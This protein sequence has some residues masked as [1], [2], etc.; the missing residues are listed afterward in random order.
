MI[1]GGADI[2]KS[3]GI[4]TPLIVA[5]EMG[6]ITVVKRLINAGVDI[7]Q[8]DGK[9]TPLIVASEKKHWIVVEELKNAETEFIDRNSRMPLT[10]IVKLGIN[11][12]SI[13]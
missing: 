10:D 5:C 8:S 4:K 3:N 6:N 13:T 2:N 11:M 9:K 7:N 12:C 1:K